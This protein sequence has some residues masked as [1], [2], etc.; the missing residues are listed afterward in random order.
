MPLLH[1]FLR[2]QSHRLK[3]LIGSVLDVVYLLKIKSLLLKY[4]RKIV[5]ENI[6]SNVELKNI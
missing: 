1:K 6:N 2:C 3:T 4:Y 5:F